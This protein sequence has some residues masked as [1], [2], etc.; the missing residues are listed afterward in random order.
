[1]Q[2][3]FF[4]FIHALKRW[5]VLS[6]VIAKKKL[7]GWHLTN[8]LLNVFILSYSQLQHQLML[9]SYNQDRQVTNPRL[10]LK[11]DTLFLGRWQMIYTP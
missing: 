9:S 8:P 11:S 5:L 10:H 3:K 7:K 4:K 2:E 1:M 6:D